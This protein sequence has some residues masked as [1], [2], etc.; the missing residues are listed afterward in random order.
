VILRTFGEAPDGC[1]MWPTPCLPYRSVCSDLLLPISRFSHHRARPKLRLKAAFRGKPSGS[2]SY[3]LATNAGK[4]GPSRRIW[5]VRI[6]L[7]GPTATPS[8]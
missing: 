8:R 3:E 1:L 7:G 4:Y 5:V 2:H 6:F